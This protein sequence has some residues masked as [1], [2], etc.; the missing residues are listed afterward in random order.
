[1]QQAPSRVQRWA[2]QLENP[3]EEIA[4]PA[5]AL[6]ATVLVGQLAHLPVLALVLPRAL[7]V[8]EW[9]WGRPAAIP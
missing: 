4:P 2:A 9:A 3:A 1:M 5:A 8:R 6:G 7:E